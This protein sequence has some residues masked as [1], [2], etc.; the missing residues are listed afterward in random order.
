M[1][2]YMTKKKKEKRLDDDFAR[3]VQLM[4]E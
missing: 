1:D 2:K 3:R 4:I